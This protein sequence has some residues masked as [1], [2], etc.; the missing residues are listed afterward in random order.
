MAQ[1]RRIQRSDP[2]YGQERSLRE[3]VLLRPI[4]LDLS[5]FE[6]EFPGIEEQFEHFVAVTHRPGASPASDRLVM[7]LDPASLGGPCVIGCAALLAHYPRPGVGKLMQMAVDRQRQGEG[8]G[9]RLVVAVEA[10]AFG[11]LGLDELFCHAQLPAIG[12]YERLGWEVDSDEF[13]E[14]NIPHRRMRVRAPASDLEAGLTDDTE[15]MP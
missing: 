14:A 5:K 1:I 4:G 8:I 15:E 11:E 9:R 7:G 12:F 3:D 13:I 10:R 6:R 2:L